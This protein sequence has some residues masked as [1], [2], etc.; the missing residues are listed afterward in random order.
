MRRLRSATT[1]RKLSPDEQKHVAIIAASC[2]QVAAI[3]VYGKADGRPDH[4][5]LGPLKRYR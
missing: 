5:N 4:G 3:D 1:Y 2:G